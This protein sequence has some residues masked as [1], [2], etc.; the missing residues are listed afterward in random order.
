MG[1]KDYFDWTGELFSV[2]KV[3]AKPEA[4][5]SVRVLELCT[6]VFGPVTADLLADFGAE[7]IKIE[8]PGVGDLMRYV[9]PRGFFW[10]NISTAVSVLTILAIFCS[11]LLCHLKINNKIKI[12]RSNLTHHV[13]HT[14]GV[15]TKPISIPS[16]FQK[17]SLFDPITCNL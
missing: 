6:R 5:K 2:S 17:P 4:L 11:R 16:S 15:T 14:G 9:A 13:P 8:L 10:Q 3:F 7:V 1:N 12:I